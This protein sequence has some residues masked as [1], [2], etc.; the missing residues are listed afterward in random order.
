MIGHAESPLNAENSAAMVNAQSNKVDLP[1]DFLVRLEGNKLQVSLDS[2]GASDSNVSANVLVRLLDSNGIEK[3][4]MS[5]Q[6]GIAEFTNVMADQLH[7]I[8]V[9]DRDAHGVIPLMTVGEQNATA[10]RVTSKLIHLPLITGNQAEILETINRDI[11][12]NGSKLGTHFNLDN[13]R[14]QSPNLYQVQL[15]S[16]G[17]LA[18]HVVIADRDLSEK[19]RYARLTFFR[20]NQVVFKAD[21]NVKDGSFSVD[22]LTT[23]VY[24]VVAAG[25]AGYTAFA[26]EVLPA[27]DQPGFPGGNILEKPVSFAQ[28]QPSKQLYVFLVPPSLVPKVTDRVREDYRQPAIDPIA[29][30]P[31]SPVPNMALGGN[32]YGGGGFGGGGFGGGSGGSGG[33]GGGGRGGIGGLAGLAGI[34]AV[35]AND[36]GNSSGVVSPITP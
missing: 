29:G 23:G 18:G 26:F 30:S 22:G 27:A 2:M 31:S 14:L 33:G 12:P 5:N 8:V 7:A 4:A 11:P 19:L 20:N 10:N 16:D 6:A 13:Y 25:P 36:F 17:S 15:Q 1:E 34:A 28:P 9:T 35:I 24:G 32:N 21:S 3:T